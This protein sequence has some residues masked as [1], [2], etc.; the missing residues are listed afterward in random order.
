MVAETTK[1]SPISKKYVPRKAASEVH[2]LN[3]HFKHFTF[4][5]SRSEG[6]GQATPDD[7][8]GEKRRAEECLID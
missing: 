1:D 7:E 6:K 3:T 8:G 2:T 5:E 4:G